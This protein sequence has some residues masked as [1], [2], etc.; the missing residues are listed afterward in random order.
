MTRPT[1]PT[2]ISASVRAK[3]LKYAQE[4]QEDFNYI[5]TRY[6]IERLLYR[7]HQHE[8]AHQFVLKGAMLFGIWTNVRHRATHDI[9]LLSSGSPELERLSTIFRSVCLIPVENDGVI[10]DPN[11]VNALR[12]RADEEYEGVRINLQ[13]F[14]GSARINLQVDI[15]FG[16]AITPGPARV[17]IPTLLD[18][19]AP[20]FA[21]YPRE[22]VIAEKFQATVSLGMGNSRM[23]DFFDIDFLSCN[24]DFDGSV[25]AAAVDATFARR[26]TALPSELPIAFTELFT[27]NISKQNQ[28]KAFLKKSK[29]SSD[30]DLA[31]VMARVQ[32]FT[33]PVVDA[34]RDRITIGTWSSSKGWM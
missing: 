33:W 25:L 6:G 16:D 2:N 12:I 21:S 5:L 30:T 11:S 14:L 15:G 32:A 18:L 4:H 13:G 29:L 19:P 24:F 9:D 7:L 26:R 28:W 22:T 3:L 8:E 1:P 17:Q 10:F 27:K 23:K 20:L 31:V 34:I